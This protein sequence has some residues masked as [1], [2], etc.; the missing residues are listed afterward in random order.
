MDQWSWGSGTVAAPIPDALKSPVPI[1]RI[2]GTGVG[3]A[4]LCTGVGTEVGTGV[5][6]GVAVGVRTRVGTGV[7]DGGRS[8]DAV[9]VGGRARLTL[10]LA[11]GVTEG[12]TVAL[13]GA[14]VGGADG[15]PVDLGGVVH[16]TPLPDWRSAAAEPQPTRISARMA[17]NA[18]VAC[19]FVCDVTG[20][21]RSVRP[22]ALRRPRRPRASPSRTAS[23]RCRG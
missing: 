16:A 5:L 12:G 1:G 10:G 13:C 23:G 17:G 7:G 20:C 15:A 2:V 18:A 9:G 19:F 4:A 8:G 22:D 6:T 11:V 3:G 21:S 14:A